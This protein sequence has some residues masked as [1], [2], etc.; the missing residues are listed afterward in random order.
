MFVEL[1]YC[2][3]PLNIC[4][5]CPVFETRSCYVTQVDLELDA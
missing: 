4:R 2:Y 5:V 1:L 3:C